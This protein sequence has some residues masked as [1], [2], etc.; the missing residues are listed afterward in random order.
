MNVTAT[1]QAAR[2]AR[3]SR[4]AAINFAACMLLLAQYL[5]GM[6]V[7]IYVV[8][9]SRHPGA[10]AGNYFSG[11]VSGIGWLI[12]DGPVWAAAHAAFG[13]ALVVAAYAAIAL[14]RGQRSRVYL[15]TA[16]LGA[17]A[18]TGAAFNGASFLNYGQAFSSMIMA[19]LWALA[20]GCYL[21]GLFCA[22]RSHLS[23]R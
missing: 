10:S 9:P 1:V 22:A 12:P 16:V 13:L 5:L 17:L 3:T 7:N 18:I 14:A 15:V 21:T 23:L 11:I 2:A 4:L 6:V 19:G 20:L 8:L